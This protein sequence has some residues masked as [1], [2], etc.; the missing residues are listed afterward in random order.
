MIERW[1]GPPWFWLLLYGA[2]LGAALYFASPA[3]A[4]PIDRYVDR[5]WPAVCSTLDEVPSV[6]GV[7]GVLEGVQRDSGFSAYD[8]SPR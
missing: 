2:I 6:S 1:L 3:K 7:A 5:S 8:R 4:D